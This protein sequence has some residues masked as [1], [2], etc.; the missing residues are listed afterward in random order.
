MK[1]LILAVAA[2]AL[3]L[4]VWTHWPR[5]DFRALAEVRDLHALD[6]EADIVVAAVEDPQRSDYVKGI[7]LAVAQINARP[8][9]LQPRA[10]LPV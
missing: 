10:G 2:V 3:G 7:E 4:S 9:R 8:G 5:E 6:T 1:R